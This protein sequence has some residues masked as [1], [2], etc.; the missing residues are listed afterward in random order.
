MRSRIVFFVVLLAGTTFALPHLAHAGIPFFGP[1]IPSSTDANGNAQTCALGWGAVIPVINNII[2]FLITL[3][4]VGLAPIMIAYAGFLFVI[5]PVNPSEKERAKTILWSTFIG[6]V[7]ALS[8][9]LIVDLIMS[10]LYKP[11][12]ATET[13]YSLVTSGGLVTVTAFS[14]KNPS[15][16]QVSASV[17]AQLNQMKTNLGGA[18]SQYQITETGVNTTVNHASGS[19][20]LDMSCFGPCSPQ[21][22]VAAI[23]AWPGS[24]KYETSSQADYDA[25]IA[26]GVPSANILGPSW[27]TGTFVNGQCSTGTG[28][29]ITAPHMSLNQ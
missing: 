27:F 7:I 14:C 11:A 29:C 10:V 23:H 3:A 22:V 28:H 6:I 17:N 26:A 20:N 19:N 13:W 18:A 5:N 8:G 16:C 21:Q 15:S 24:V 25:M 2:E 1:I 9:W 12:T 4:L